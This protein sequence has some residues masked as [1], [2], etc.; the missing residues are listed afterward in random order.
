M[1]PNCDALEILGLSTGEAVSGSRRATVTAP[2]LDDA[3]AELYR[4]LP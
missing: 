2:L 4:P 1:P 3:A